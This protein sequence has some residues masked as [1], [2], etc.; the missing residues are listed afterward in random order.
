MESRPHMNSN[1]DVIGVT[2]M[3]RNGR[4]EGGQTMNDAKT[5]SSAC[6]IYVFTFYSIIEAVSSSGYIVSKVRIID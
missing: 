6:R 5:A 1:C 2:Q 3:C 4:S